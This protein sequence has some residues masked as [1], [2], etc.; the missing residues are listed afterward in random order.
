MREESESRTSKWEE[1]CDSRRQQK[2]ER[3]GSA[4]TCDERLFHRRAAATGK[5]LSPTVNRR[6]LRRYSERLNASAYGGQKPTAKILF[7]IY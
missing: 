7:C 4:V 6:R 3:E 5:A 1:K 2:M